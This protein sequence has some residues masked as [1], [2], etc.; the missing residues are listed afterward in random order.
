MAD[1]SMCKFFDIISSLLFIAIA[2]FW[3]PETA[4]LECED[5]I[6]ISDNTS[7]SYNHINH[8]L[9]Q[10]HEHYDTFYV[11]HNFGHI[12]THTAWA[13]NCTEQ[14]KSQYQ[15]GWSIL[16]VNETSCPSNNSSFL[17]CPQHGKGPPE[18]LGGNIK[19]QQ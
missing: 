7:H 5:W 11:Q 16:Y 14:F 1:Q 2:H 3:D 8:Y 13:D 4:K 10:I 18:G 17:L 12:S 15:L 19:K 9:Q 6:F